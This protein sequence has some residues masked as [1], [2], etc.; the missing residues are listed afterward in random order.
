MESA[1]W[2]QVKASVPVG[3][4]VSGR[5]VG[6]QPFGVFVDLGLGFPGL[7]EV[8]EFAEP[9]ARSRGMEGYPA[10]DAVIT[11]RVLQHV[12]SGRQL[13]LTQRP[14]TAEEWEQVRVWVRG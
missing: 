4:E 1:D 6:C 11:A 10:V 3:T 2:D 7:L 14:L 13:R 9:P 8:P 12:D 5:V